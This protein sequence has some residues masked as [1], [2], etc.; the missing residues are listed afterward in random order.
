MKHATELGRYVILS[1]NVPS[2]ERASFDVS[3]RRASRTG[4]LF[5]SRLYIDEDKG[6]VSNKRI[7]V[8]S[9]TSSAP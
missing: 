8:S 5:S 2:H 6:C 3:E 4:C 1:R 7:F 9:F